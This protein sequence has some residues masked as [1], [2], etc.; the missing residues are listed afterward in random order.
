MVRATFRH[1]VSGGALLVC[2]VSATHA[3]VL[4]YFGDPKWWLN[5]ALSMAALGLRPF[6]AEHRTFTVF[7]TAMFALVAATAISAT[8]LSLRYGSA[9]GF[10]LL[11][12][13]FA[14]LMITS[15][16]ISHVVKWLLVV[17]LTGT[18]I[19]LDQAGAAPGGAS[20]QLLAGQADAAALLRA[21][22]LAALGLV[23]PALVNQY[24]QLV[25]QQQGKLLEL[26]LRDPLTGLFNRRHVHEMGA[27]L[28]AHIARGAPVHSVVLID[29]DHFKAINDELGHDTGDLALK[30]AAKLL[31]EQARASDIVC[32]WGGEEFLVLLPQTRL[33][34]ALVFAERFRTRLSST[35]MQA[36]G[37]QL[38]FTATIGV[39]VAGVSDSLDSLVARADKALYEGKRGGR[40]RVVSAE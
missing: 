21:T 14:P 31:R 33:E 11:L 28:L 26:A 25:T 5:V 18:V 34:L 6:F 20:M 39:A 35:P 37:R 2:A 12:F 23:M 15:G 17:A 38:A 40:N 32:R 30:H 9:A 22:N 24:F 13:G 27:T 36:A 29:L 7:V 4:F 1:A 19:A 10:H 16:R 8:D 3:L